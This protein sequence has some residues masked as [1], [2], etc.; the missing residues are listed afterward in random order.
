MIKKELP[1]A[2]E[3]DIINIKMRRN[4]SD[5]T[6]ETYKLK[7]FTFEHSQPEYFLELMKNF[8]R[9]VNGIGTTTA[10][11]KIKYLRILLCG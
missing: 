1:E 6:S 3:Y 8:K 2:N 11:G 4:P 9:A 7:I 5:A 10:A